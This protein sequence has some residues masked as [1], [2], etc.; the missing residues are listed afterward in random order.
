[1]DADLQHDE[2]ILPKMLTY[3]REG[4]AELV[5]ATRY[6]GTVPVLSRSSSAR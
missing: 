4:S 3:L 1:M 5:V 2:A 6:A